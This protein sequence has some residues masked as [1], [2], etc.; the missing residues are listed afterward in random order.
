VITCDLCQK[1]FKTNREIQDS[2]LF[3]HIGAYQV[4][5][6]C[7]ELANDIRLKLLSDMKEKATLDFKRAIKENFPHAKLD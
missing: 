6:G 5:V 4:C 3:S 7:A 2:D 1:E